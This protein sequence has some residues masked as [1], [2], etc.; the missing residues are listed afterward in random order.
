MKVKDEII[1]ENNS[2]FLWEISKEHSR[3]YKL[4]ENAYA[5]E[6][7]LNISV[8]IAE[9]TEFVFGKRRITGLED[10]QVLSKI[11]INEAV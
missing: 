11:C 6:N 3:C 4:S 1:P 9:L 10:I 5:K 7:I 8:S 2:Q